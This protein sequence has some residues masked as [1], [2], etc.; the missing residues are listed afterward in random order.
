MGRVH[1]AAHRM[2][3]GEIHAYLL[4]ERDSIDASGPKYSFDA[5]TANASRNAVEPER[6]MHAL[7]TTAGYRALGT[8]RS[9][10]PAMRAVYLSS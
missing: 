2:G 6:P 4:N 1:D 3:G 5:P 8:V 9:L 10:L 7:T